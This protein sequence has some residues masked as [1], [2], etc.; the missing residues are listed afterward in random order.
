MICSVTSGCAAG[1]PEAR[2]ARRRGVSKYV[3]SPAGAEPF[4]FQQL[5]HALPQFQRR[6]INHA[7]RDL[8]AAD[9]EQKVRHRSIYPSSQNS[10]IVNVSIV[11]PGPVNPDNPAPDARGDVILVPPP[12]SPLNSSK[13]PGGCPPRLSPTALQSFAT[14][15]TATQPAPALSSP[16]ALCRLYFGN[17]GFSLRRLLLF[18]RLLLQVRLRN[19]HRQRP[20]S[21]NH[22]HPLG[23][24]NSSA[25]IQHIEKM[26]TLQAQVVRSQQRKPLDFSQPSHLPF[27][28]S[29]LLNSA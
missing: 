24:R 22:S 8:F 11:T 16:D 27:D 5:S 10:N 3:T 14:Q 29:G 21:R 12:A 18:A 1:I 13:A 2:T 25:R 9:F 28:L 19:S 15:S 20:N 26:R 4:P 17:R 6:R 7:R 23:H